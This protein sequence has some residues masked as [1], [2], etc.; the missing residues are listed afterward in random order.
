IF[1]EVEGELAANNEIFVAEGARV[2]A[3]I[4]A[5]VIIVAGT[6]DGT[7]ECSGRLEVLPSGRVS[8]EVFAPTL[9]VH[10]GATVDGD[11]KMQAAESAG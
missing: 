4:A 6:V 3:R 5:Q 7:L 1:G 10:E 2:N 8:G 9:V 11:L